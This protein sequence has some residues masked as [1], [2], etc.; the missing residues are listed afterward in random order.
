MLAKGPVAVILAC[1]ILV[2]WKR[3][4]WPSLGRNILEFLRP[5][6]IVPFIAVAL[7]WYALCTWA[8]GTIFLKVFFWQHNVER[9]VSA[10]EIGRHGPAGLL[11]R[12]PVLA[13]LLP[14]TPAPAD[15]PPSLRTR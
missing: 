7:P 4:F 3:P 10:A 1:P 13:L 2:P 8:N 11:F 14:W 12:V 6:V 5:R 9:F 15:L